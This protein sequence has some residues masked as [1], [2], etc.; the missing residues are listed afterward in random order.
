MIIQE[1][2][3]TQHHLLIPRQCSKLEVIN[4]DFLKAE[5]AALKYF[6]E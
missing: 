6:D 5:N 2:L 3:H 4:I 1:F